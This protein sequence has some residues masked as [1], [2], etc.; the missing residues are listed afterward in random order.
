M[1]HAHKNVSSIFEQKNHNSWKDEAVRHAKELED[2]IRSLE[3]QLQASS[4]EKAAAE[5]SASTLRARVA[6]LEE[7]GVRASGQG[8]AEMIVLEND[9]EVSLCTCLCLPKR[10]VALTYRRAR[11]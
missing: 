7:D 5:G 6:A 4:E 11:S 3:S 8:R 9:I 2:T 1:S 10:Y